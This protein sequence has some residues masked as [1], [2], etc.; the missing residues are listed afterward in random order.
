MAKK[1]VQ[2]IYDMQSISTMASLASF[3]HYD[4]AFEMAKSYYVRPSPLH[5]FMAP[6]GSKSPTHMCIFCVINE[7]EIGT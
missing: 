6:F 7:T 2:F 4:L 5:E 1:K 3:A